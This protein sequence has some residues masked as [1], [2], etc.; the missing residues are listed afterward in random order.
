MPYYVPE[1][2]QDVMAEISLP[3]SAA[4]AIVVPHPVHAG[5]RRWECKV[6][7]PKHIV[8]NVTFVSMAAANVQ[9]VVEG[10]EA[11]GR[12]VEYEELNPMV[13]LKDLGRYE[14]ST[15]PNEVFNAFK[16]KH[17]TVVFHN[18]AQ[19]MTPNML[20][21]LQSINPHVKFW[22]VVGIPVGGLGDEHS[23][24]TGCG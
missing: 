24:E 23:L 15:V 19:Y 12:V 11:L 2:V 18:S 14:F 9:W 6:A 17:Q 7:L 20:L 21:Y 1:E 4:S 16:F 3:W 13:D 10:L 5:V 8:T 22:I